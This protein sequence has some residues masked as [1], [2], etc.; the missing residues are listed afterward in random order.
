VELLT[1][2]WAGAFRHPH[3]KNLFAT[4]TAAVRVQME[5]GGDADGSKKATRMALLD[6][7]DAVTKF[8]A[9]AAAELPAYQSVHA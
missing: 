7:G 4:L 9:D 3:F 5:E 6:C 2:T 1:A 8:V